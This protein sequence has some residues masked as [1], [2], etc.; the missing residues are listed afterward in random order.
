MSATPVP[1]PTDDAEALR[2]RIAALEAENER[3]ASL[4]ETAPIEPLVAEEPAR[5]RRNGWRAFVSALCIVIAS[6]LVPV[7]VVAAWARAELVNPDQFV[8]T[9]GPLVDDPDVQALVIDEVTTAVNEQV[10]IAGITND[11]FDGISELDLPPRAL[12][13]IDLLRAPAIQG[14]EGLIDQTV[15][16]VV[17]SD[18]FADV[19]DGA[20]RASHRALVAA[21]TGG[22]SGAI[23]IDDQGVIGIQLG[24]IVEEV[25]QRLIDRGVGFASAIPEVDRTIV[26][27]QSD[28]LATVRVVYGLA[29]TVGWWLPVIA[30]ILFVA[31]ILFARRKST[32]VLGAGIG[33]A[34]G[35]ATLAIGLAIGGTVIGVSAASLGLPS[36]ALAV[37]YE[38]VIGAMKQTAVVGVVLGI[39]IAVFA[40]VQGRWAG[41]VATRGAIGG[42]NDSIRGALA[43]RG[44]DTGGFG[45]WMDRQRVLVRIVIGVLAIIWL[46]LLRPLGVGEIFLVLIVALIVWWLCELVRRPS[47][48][49]VVIVVADE[50]VDAE[51]VERVGETPPGGGAFD[52]VDEGESRRV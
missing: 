27:A 30:L 38:Q 49:A 23:V 13:A 51:E 46:W 34:V 15:T 4:A 28:A 14:V 37:V 22:E 39:V 1:A 19:W 48:D 26:I 24:P 5:R 50:S 36:D 47:A 52:V 20:L 44:V 2:A 31:G 35:A 41:A 17:E 9:F 40:W 43:G 33:L 10:D 29:V 6:I 3:L 42:V 7:S 12:V 8:A 32:A 21:A 16:R 45:A 25:K 18:Q 11:L